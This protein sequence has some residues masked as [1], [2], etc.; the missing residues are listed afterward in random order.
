LF[1]FHRER[2]VRVSRNGS[3]GPSPQNSS[4]ELYDNAD[5]P[6]NLADAL[7][8]L[9]FRCKPEYRQRGRWVMSS[10]NLAVVRKL[11]GSDGHFLWQPGLGSGVDAG[12]G[13]LLGKPVHTSEEF[14]NVDLLNSP[15]FG[16]PIVFGDF[17]VG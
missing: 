10:T 9:H 8:D 11:K 2:G 1:A 6:G 14:G 4:I 3:L 17:E 16:S 13:V 15:A 7:I 12:D 5:S